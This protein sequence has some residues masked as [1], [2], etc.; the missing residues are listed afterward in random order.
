MKRGWY[1]MKQRTGRVLG[2]LCAGCMAVS[3]AVCAMPAAAVDGFDPETAVFGIHAEGKCG[4]NVTWSLDEETGTLTISGTGD[5]KMT[6]RELL[7]GLMPLADSVTSIVIGEGVTGICDVAFANYENLTSVSLPESLKTIGRDAFRC[8]KQLAELTIPEGVEDIGVYA[9]LATPWLEQQKETESLV[10]AGKVLI[11]CGNGSIGEPLTEAEYHAIAGDDSYYYDGQLYQLTI[12]DGVKTIASEA[13]TGCWG[14]VKLTIP[15]GVEKIGSNAF[16]G[17]YNLQQVSLPDSL[18]EVGSLAFN[19][20]GLGND[21]D[22][23]ESVWLIARDAFRATAWLEQKQATEP[24]VI[25][26]GILIAAGTAKTGEVVIPDGVEKIG[27][28]AFCQCEEITSVVMPDSVTEIGEGAFAGCTQLASVHFPAGLESVSRDAFYGCTAL[29]AVDLPEGVRTVGDSAFCGCTALTELDLP[30]LLEEIGSRAFAECPSLTE[31]D[32]PEALK[33]IGEGAF[34]EDGLLSVVLPEGLESLGVYA[35]SENGQLGDITIPE[36]LLDIGAGAFDETLWQSHH[37]DTDM[38]VILNDV[39]MRGGTEAIGEIAVPAGVREIADDA[40]RDCTELLKVLIPDTVTKIGDGAFE[41]CGLTEVLIPAS[42]TELGIGAFAYC[43]DL[44]AVTLPDDLKTIGT[45]AFYGCQNLENIIVPSGVTEIAD[46]AF[47]ACSKLTLCGEAGSCAES[48]AKEHRIPFRV[49]DAD[50]TGD[51]NCSGNVDVSDAVLLAR[52]LVSDS[53]AV[54]SG[55]GLANADCDKNGWRDDAD[56]TM[57][58]Q[59]IAKK[60]TF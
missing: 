32:F 20:A 54:I 30:A 55:Q 42:V 22:I 39:L 59:Y 29:A 12:P 27:P 5:M 58:L 38:F 41:N 43:T 37:L 36:G 51:V 53:G 35:F 48:Y 31:V 2:I 21:F 25:I 14:M 34:S 52:Y 11:C 47:A 13:F 3:G 19:A 56:L 46:N 33:Y 28:Y 1:M 45:S 4:D 50:P 16:S 9:F 7:L 44:T 60:I 8:C 10:I 15:E 6:D 26:N 49:L 24:F 40:F 57:I 23:P 17:C 18:R